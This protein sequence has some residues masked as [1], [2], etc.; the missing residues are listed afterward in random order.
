MTSIIPPITQP[1]AST[2]GDNVQPSTTPSNAVTNQPNGFPLDQMLDPSNPQWQAVKEQEMNGVFNYYTN[3]LFLMGQGYQFTFDANLSTAIGGYA[4]GSILF[5]VS[6]NTYQIS[7]INNNTFNFVTTP[8]YINDGIHWSTLSS[9][10]D[11]VDNITTGEVTIGDRILGSSQ[12]LVTRT[13]TDVSIVETF[14]LVSRTSNTLNAGGKVYSF[15]AN[16]NN[17]IGGLNFA[18][19]VTEADN[20]TLNTGIIGQYGNRP[21]LIRPTLLTTI[22]ESIATLGDIDNV[23]NKFHLQPTSNGYMTF[24]TTMTNVKFIMQWGITNIPAGSSAQINL[25]IYFPNN[26]VGVFITPIIPNSFMTQGGSPSASFLSGSE[27]AI[28]NSLNAT[29]TYYFLAI[30]Y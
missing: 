22:S 4:Q 20:V 12:K 26:G 18:L 23:A 2:R 1:F 7:L 21:K 13:A 9:L 30:G 19:A 5:C 10:P 15:C 6:N 27:I 17:T 3:L 8:S 25:P 11:V 29:T 24:Y 28:Y 16:G 14:S